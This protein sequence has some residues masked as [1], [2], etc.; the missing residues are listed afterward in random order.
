MR[1]ENEE[2][3][4]ERVASISPDGLDRQTPSRLSRHT[5][6]LSRSASLA[7]VSRCSFFQTSMFFLPIP[8]APV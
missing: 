8:T 2:A 3:G 1:G 6:P 5:C 7:R 4:R